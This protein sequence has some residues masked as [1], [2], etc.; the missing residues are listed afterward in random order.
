MLKYPYY[1]D[2]PKLKLSVVVTVHGTKEYFS[3]CRKFPDGYY[4]KGVDLVED[5]QGKWVKPKLRPVKVAPVVKTIIDHET[6]KEVESTSGLR[7]GIVGFDE[8]NK[9]IYGYYTP[10][11]YKNVIV[12]LQRE[13]KCNVISESILNP[14]NFQEK[15]SEGVYYETTGWRKDS[16]EDLKRKDLAIDNNRHNYNIEDDPNIYARAIKLYEN[17][18]I[19]LDN[20]IKYLSNYIKGVSFGVE[21]ET[22]NGILPKHIL[23]KYGVIIC[24]DGSIKDR[25]GHYPPEYVTVPLIGAKGLQTLRNLSK[26]IALRSDIDIKC[27]YHVH[28]G[29]MNIDRVLMVALFR[30]C[31]KIQNDVFRMFPYYKTEPNGFKEKNYCKKLP[32]VINAYGAKDFNDYINNSYQDICTFLSGGHRLDMD[33]NRKAKINPWGGEKWNI[34]TRYYWVNF[35]NPVFGK[36]DTIEFRIHTPTLNADK[37]INWLMM[38]IAIIKYAETNPKDCVTTKKVTFTDVLSHYGNSRGTSFGNH[39]SKRLIEYY[40]NRVEY[41]KKDFERGDYQ[42][43]RELVEDQKF[44]FNISSLNKS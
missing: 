3:N 39:L 4:V 1:K 9:P 30:L 8:K 41:F 38:C 21:L 15:Y 14:A 40:E 7:S 23:A 32:A 17:S 31:S 13:G 34:K 26:E 29:G 6:G 44:E 16:I 24:K 2:N 33:F 22:I 12:I 20:D 19:P 10:N 5:A 11:E 42:S 35:V 28:I 37:I 25:N 43:N 36:R 27:S 18:N